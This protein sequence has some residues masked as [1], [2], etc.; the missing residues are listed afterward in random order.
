MMTASISRTSKGARKE[1][2]KDRKEGRQEGRTDGEEEGRTAGKKEGRNTPDTHHHVQQHQRA[3]TL[4]ASHHCPLRSPDDIGQPPL[5]EPGVA[6]M[7]P[8]EKS[9]CR[10]GC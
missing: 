6:L 4:H 5:L 10:P 2:R 7:A 9:R 3:C 1:G 8:E